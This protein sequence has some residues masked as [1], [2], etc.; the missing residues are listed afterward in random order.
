MGT[1]LQPQSPLEHYG[2]TLFEMYALPH[3][4]Q[5]TLNGDM[6]MDDHLQYLYP[7]ST[8]QCRDSRRET[9]DSYG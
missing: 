6:G 5:R 1:L 4:L 7:R 8:T 2:S 9:L 3:I